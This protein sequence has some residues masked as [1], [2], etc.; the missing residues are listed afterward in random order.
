MHLGAEIQKDL[1]PDPK[2]NERPLLM[3]IELFIEFK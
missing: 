1:F 2:T 3:S